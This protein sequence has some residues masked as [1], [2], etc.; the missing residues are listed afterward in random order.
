M[1]ILY[2]INSR[3]QSFGWGLVL[4]MFDESMESM[5][6]QIQTV[7][8]VRASLRVHSI[9]RRALR[10]GLA[11]LRVSSMLQRLVCD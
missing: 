11:P 1:I 10:H 6:M 7:R 4:I 8:P 9:E 5:L 2:S 3:P